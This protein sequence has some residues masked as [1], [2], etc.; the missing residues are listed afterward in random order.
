MECSGLGDS[1]RRWFL[2]AL[3]C[4]DTFGQT[5]QHLSQRGDQ[6]GS[7]ASL[8][9]IFRAHP[10][11]DDVRFRN[12]VTRSDVPCSETILTAASIASCRFAALFLDAWIHLLSLVHVSVARA[13]FG[14]RAF[15]RS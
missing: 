4:V 1:L 12:H 9:R 7:S 6:F 15:A 5:R 14:Q 11:G 2:G 13:R 8:Q 3:E 10:P